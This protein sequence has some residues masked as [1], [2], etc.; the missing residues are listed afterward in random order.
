[1][2][3]KV[4]NITE[5]YSLLKEAASRRA[6]YQILKTKKLIDQR[7]PRQNKK[8]EKDVYDLPVSII[9]EISKYMWSKR[10]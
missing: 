6:K 7:I 9:C 3:A 10:K 5:L 4:E 8:V 2:N 1:M